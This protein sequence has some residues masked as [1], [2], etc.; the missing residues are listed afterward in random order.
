MKYEYEYHI[1]WWLISKKINLKARE[2]AEELAQIEADAYSNYSLSHQSSYH[3]EN[4]Q[5][6]KSQ[7]KPENYS[8]ETYELD[9][10]ISEQE[11]KMK[12][13]NSYNESA[14]Q[15]QNLKV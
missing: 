5:T 2:Q 6:I 8:E 13:S 9:K 3:S 12:K 10:I 15:Y 11:K 4:V 1:K 7:S 14:L